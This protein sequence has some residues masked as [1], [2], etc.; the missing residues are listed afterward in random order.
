M[1][2]SKFACL[3]LLLVA[4]CAAQNTLPPLPAPL[5]VPALGPSTDGPYAPQ[6]IHGWTLMI[7]LSCT[8]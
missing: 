4:V 8:S 2:I 5:G 7:C 1:L 6:P 3:P